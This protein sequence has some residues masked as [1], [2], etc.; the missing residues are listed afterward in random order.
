M[1]LW[2]QG[3]AG[4]SNRSEIAAA[5]QKTSA[6]SLQAGVGLEQMAAMITVVS[7]DLRVSAETIG[8]AFSR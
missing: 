3:L 7:S 6:V 1:L 5:L 8:Q 4:F 2:S